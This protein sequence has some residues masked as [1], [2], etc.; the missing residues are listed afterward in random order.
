MPCGNRTW[1]G[2]RLPFAS[3]LVSP[4]QSSRLTY[5]YPAASRPDET[6]M[7]A[8][9]LTMASLKSA[10]HLVEF[11]LLKPIGGVRANPLASAEAGGA[12]NTAEP[13]TA[14]ARARPVAASAEKSIR[15]LRTVVLLRNVRAGRDRRCRGMHGASGGGSRERPRSTWNV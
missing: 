8:I 7:S 5:W 13:K 2:T 10:L 12:V 11:Q 3:R 9:P 1:L 4:Q 14:A 15:D 6:K